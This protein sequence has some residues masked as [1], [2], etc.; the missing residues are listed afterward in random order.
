MPK[1]EMTPYEASIFSEMKKLS[2]RANQR[3]LRLERLTGANEPF[4]T[5]QLADY[6]SSN[7]L[8]VWTRKGRVGVKSDLSVLQMKSVIKA[9]KQFLDSRCK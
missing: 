4:A 7:L 9:T 6:L 2:K 8:N 1:R 5:K 3:I